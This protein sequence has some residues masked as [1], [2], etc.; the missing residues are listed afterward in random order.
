ML[1][2]EPFRLVSNRF[3][4]CP[5]LLKEPMLGLF[6]VCRAACGM[7][8]LGILGIITNHIIGSSY[9]GPAHSVA[10]ACSLFERVRR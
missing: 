10:V 5:F 7:H 9:F 8:I 6:P 3:S 2:F 1:S 4:C